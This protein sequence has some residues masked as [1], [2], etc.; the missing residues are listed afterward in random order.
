MSKALVLI[1]VPVVAG[2]AAWNLYLS[3]E[4]DDLRSQVGEGASAATTAGKGETSGAAALSSVPTKDAAPRA[5]PRIAELEHRLAAMERRAAAGPLPASGG[6]PH[7]PS[8]APD[9]AEGASVPIPHEWDSESFR[10]AV[11][12][13]LEAR[14]V[15]RREDRSGRTAE[16][17][18]RLWFQGITFTG[19][20][21]ADALKVV[22]DSIRR[23]DAVRQDASLTE[24]RR[25]EEFQRIQDDRMTAL[26]AV[27]DAQQMETVRQRI[28]SRVRRNAEGGRGVRAERGGD[29]GSSETR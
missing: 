18:G 28:G 11:T 25:R 6:H 24:E 10:A 14:E 4:L 19:T 17:L 5:D 26:S 27:L 2:L 22:E 23:M 12:K 20:Q 9:A 21:H 8:E 15:A 13:V 7:E 29:D 3:S 16:N 1:L